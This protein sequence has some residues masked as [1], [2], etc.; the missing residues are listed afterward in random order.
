M[1]DYELITEVQ[2]K[3]P[4]GLNRALCWREDPPD[5]VEIWLSP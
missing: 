4:P 3:L 2:G 1:M 5:V